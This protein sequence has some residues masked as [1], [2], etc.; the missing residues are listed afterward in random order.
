MDWLLAEAAAHGIRLTPVLLNTWKR[1]N[2]IPLF[3][4]W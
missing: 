1:N 3:E 4:E 2:G